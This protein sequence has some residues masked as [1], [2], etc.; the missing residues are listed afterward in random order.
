MST[1]FDDLISALR[2]ETGATWRSSLAALA[3]RLAGHLATG[4]AIGI[5]VAV[6]LAIAG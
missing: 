3:L 1:V 6:G 4:V 2:A 5:G